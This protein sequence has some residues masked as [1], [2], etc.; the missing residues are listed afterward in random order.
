MSYLN[1]YIIKLRTQSIQD[2][3]NE[4]QELIKEFN[5]KFDCF[6]FIY[7]SCV[8]KRIPENQLSITD[9]EIIHDLLLN[10]SGKKIVF[11]LETLG[12]SGEAAKEIADL[13]RFKFEEVHFLIAGK[14]M[15]AGTIL[16]LSGDE[17]LMTETGSL[18]P[19]DAQVLIGRSLVSAHGYIDWV[20]NTRNYA[21]QNGRLNPF[22][23]TMVAQISPG[24]L[25]QVTNA[26]NFAINLVKEWLPKYK[27][28]NWDRTKTR[29]IS[30]TKEMKY[31]R[32]EEIAQELANQK[33]WN[34]HS[35]PLKLSDLYEL[36]LQVIPVEHEPDGML[37]IVYKIKTI[38]RMIFN[39]TS[40][41]KLFI[42]DSN[43][44]HRL[45]TDKQAIKPIIPNNEINVF[46]LDLKCGKCDKEFHAYGKFKDDKKFD[47]EMKNEGYDPIPKEKKIKCTCGSIIDLVGILSNVEAQTGKRIIF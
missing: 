23:A 44:V 1:E 15:S 42:T 7:A 32:A 34:T 4:Q 24:E 41:F 36:G 29:G 47:D 43:K 45:S 33:K 26:Y 9:Y 11:F 22:D 46:K 12:G 10:I 38:N 27:F 2:L 40:A 20:D 31:K 13:L 25:T 39:A 5:K 21:E 14:A 35:R 18:G 30:V 28:K 37:D 3:E 16:A 8:E 19:I 17:I 6:L